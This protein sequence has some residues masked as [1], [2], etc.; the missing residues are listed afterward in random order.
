MFFEP[1]PLKGAYLISLDKKED[2]RGFFAR[3][4]CEKEFA[5]EGLVC[6]FPQCNISYNAKKGTLRGMHYS[7]APF[8]ETKVVRCLRGKAYDVLVDLRKNSATFLK[9]IAV[10]LSDQNRLMVYIPEGIAHGFQALDDETEL[11]YHMSVPYDAQCARGACWDDPLL[12]IE[13]PI[14]NPII[15]Q[16]DQEFARIKL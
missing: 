12:K 14:E 15:S 5:K 4:F 6:Q 2:E 8:A 3:S 11:F 1:L 10:E 13:W 16:R 9:W 7:V